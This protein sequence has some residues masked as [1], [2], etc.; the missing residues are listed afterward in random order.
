AGTMGGRGAG[1]DASLRPLVTGSHIDTVPSGGKYDG[2]VGSLSAVE[3][4]QT[5]ADNGVATRHP[6]EVIIFQNEE[7]GLFGSRAL[8]GDLREA[9]LDLVSPSGKTVRDGINYIGGDATRLDSARRSPGDI[10]AFIEYHIEQG[11]ILEMRSKN[12]G[13]VTGIVAVY[14]WDV[15]VGG[16]ANHAGTTPMNARKDALLAAAEFIVAVHRVVTSTAGA[17][18][19]TVGRLVAIPGAVNVIAGE[20]HLALELRAL[21]VIKVEA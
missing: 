15:T 7:Q 19:G 11:P 3:L 9:E 14:R 18:V 2:C 13:V 4:A 17:Q 10:A 21:D 12:I 5:L 16:M 8:S 1:A 6:L 20:V